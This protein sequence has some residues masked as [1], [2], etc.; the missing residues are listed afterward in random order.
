M[1][2]ESSLARIGRLEG[3]VHRER[4]EQILPVA[5]LKGERLPSLGSAPKSW[6]PL[7]FSFLDSTLPGS[8]EGCLG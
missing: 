8:T 2:D 6:T 4:S 5:S 3:A 7:A 1:G